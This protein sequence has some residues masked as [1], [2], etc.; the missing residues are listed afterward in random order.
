MQPK[1]ITKPGPQPGQII[2]TVTGATGAPARRA[3]LQFM[4][5]L[6]RT[7]RAQF[8]AP[9]PQFTVGTVA[10]VTGP[11]PAYLV[12]PGA[13]AA[14]QQPVVVVAGPAPA[15]SQLSLF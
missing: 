11:A 2:V 9:R 12:T 10:T 1:I 7:C 13:L 6:P 3:L 5:A 4:R 14:W 15:I 8:I